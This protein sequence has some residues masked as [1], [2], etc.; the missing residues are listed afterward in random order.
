MARNQRKR[1]GFGSVRQLRSGRYQASYFGPDGLR[2]LS[3]TTFATITDADVWLSTVRADIIRKVW[4]APRRSVERVDAYVARWIEQRHGLKDTTRALYR[5]VYR[6][7][8]KDSTIGVLPLVDLTPDRVRTW[9]H[10]L[11]IAKHAELA[12][13]RSKADATGRPFSQATTRTG[14]ALVRQAFILLRAALA[15]ATSD[16]LIEVNPCAGITGAG[17]AKLGERPILSAAEVR[18]LA[19][20][21]YPRY[22]ALVLLAAFSGLRFGELAA[23]RRADLDLSSG[24]ASVSVARRVYK[25]GG[26]L[27]FDSPKSRA[28]TR[29]VSLPDVIAI[30]LNNHLRQYSDDAV[31]SL[32]FT[33]GTGGVLTPANLTSAWARARRKID[34]PDI[35]FHDLRH[36]GQTLAALAGATQAELMQRLGHSTAAAALGYMHATQ[37]H[38]RAVAQAL[39]QHLANPVQQKPDLPAT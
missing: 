24:R 3:G 10:D 14:A 31:D 23:L 20:V 28:G 21:I 13:R 36:T 30:E 4:K 11:G 27:N 1:R 22:R 39:N 16:R 38:S 8:I 29:V 26:E 18:K 7:T 5:N 6:A 19:E 9:H 37:D 15:T 25:L 12:A 35:R 2:Y 34:R 33:T 17:Q 32:V